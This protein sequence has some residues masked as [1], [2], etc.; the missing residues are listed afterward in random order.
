MSDDIALARIPSR[1][2]L[3]TEDQTDGLPT[4]AL[5]RVTVVRDQE[6]GFRLEKELEP[7]LFNNIL[8]AVGFLEIANAGDFAAN[9]WNEDPVPLFA[10]ILMGLGGTLALSM[11]YFA[12]RDAIL[13]WKNIVALR[14][15]RRFLKAQRARYTGDHQLMRTIDA[16]LDC[17]LREV[18]CEYVNRLGMD[19]LMGFGALVVGVGTFLAIDGDDESI[20][21]GSNQ[22]TGYIGN[23]PCAL[24]GLLNLVWSFHLSFRAICHSRAGSSHLVEANAGV[25]RMLHNRTSS[26]RFHSA[27]NGIAA[28]VAGAAS[29]ATATM[30]WGYVVLLPCL[31]TSVLVNYFWRHRVGYERPLVQSLQGLNEETILDTL[32]YLDWCIQRAKDSPEDPLATLVHDRTSL[33]IVMEF[34]TDNQLFEGFCIRVMQDADLS[35]V[36]FP[37]AQQHWTITWRDMAETTDPSTVARL[38]AVADQLVRDKAPLC[39][40][41]Q[42]RY[43]LEVLGSYMCATGTKKTTTRRP[44]TVQAQSR[45]AHTYSGRHGDDWLFGGFKVTELVK[46]AFR[47]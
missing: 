6:G 15:E 5:G 45:N 8:L 40:K 35:S 34:I 26:V 21:L 36:V 16:L 25:E 1:P 43:L 44:P 19:C 29:M 47:T 17:N 46:Q 20:F 32:R 13:S 7:R 4:T 18:G 31:A 33:P 27:L 12:V 42:Q 3:P 41:N 2:E 37:G 10:K 24:Y 38:L 11:I 39:F 14:V 9:V 30:W 23:S 22:L 28:C